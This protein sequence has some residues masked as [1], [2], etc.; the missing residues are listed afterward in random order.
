MKRN[1]KKIP[2]IWIINQ[3][4]NTPTMPGGTRHYEIADYF[5][6]L[7][8]DIEV[9]SSDFSLSFRKFMILKKFEFNS[10]PAFASN[11]DFLLYP[12]KS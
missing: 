10:I 8:W 2:K 12:I 4:A 11:I 6:K 7:K 9:F 3:F 1:I 5:S